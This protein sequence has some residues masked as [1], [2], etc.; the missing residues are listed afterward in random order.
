MVA[1]IMLVSAL[2]MGAVAIWVLTLS[3]PTPGTSQ[4]MQKPKEVGK[5]AV[6]ELPKSHLVVERRVGFGRIS[7]ELPPV[8][9]PQTFNISGSD[10]VFSANLKAQDKVKLSIKATAPIDFEV[11]FY[12]IIKPEGK[13][14][15][16]KSETIIDRIQIIS[17]DHELN[18]EKDGAYRFRF[19]GGTPGTNTTVTFD[20]YK[21]ER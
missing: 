3:N 13:P 18:L 4:E 8:A 17:L 9:L 1:A 5:E 12:S 2:V 19:N 15:Y 16:V 10:Y 14:D 21:I 7:A 11:F 6:K 20:A